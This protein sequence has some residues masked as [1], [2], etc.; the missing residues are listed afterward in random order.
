MYD[1]AIKRLKLRYKEE[2]NGYREEEKKKQELPVFNHDRILY[3]K[4]YNAAM[5]RAVRRL[6][7]AHSKEF[8][9]LKWE[10]RSNAH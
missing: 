9:L 10:I 1:E 7:K 6:I 8:T 3:R 4:K 5:K 2:F